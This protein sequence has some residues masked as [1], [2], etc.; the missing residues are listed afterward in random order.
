VIVT[1]QRRVCDFQKGKNKGKGNNE[2]IENEKN[3]W[4]RQRSVKAFGQ[5]RQGDED[6]SLGREG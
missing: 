5:K 6:R 4:E 3:S 2:V 1:G